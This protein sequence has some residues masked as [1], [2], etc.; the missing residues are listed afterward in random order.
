MIILLE[1]FN[2]FFDIY[3]FVNSVCIYLE[4][5]FMFFF[6]STRIGKIDSWK[7]F[8]NQSRKP[9]RVPWPTRIVERRCCRH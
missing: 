1:L 5:K 4:E 7:I 6:I 2:K 9:F 3:L 8:E